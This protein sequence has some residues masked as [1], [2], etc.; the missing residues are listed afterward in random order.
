MTDIDRLLLSSSRNPHVRQQRPPHRRARR[1]RHRSRGDGAGAGSAAQDRGDDRSEIPLHRGA[2][3]RQSLSRDRQV[4][5]GKHDPAVRRGRRDPARRLRPAVG[6]LPRQHRD[7]AADRAARSFR[8][9]CRGAA[10]A[11]HS[12]RAEPDRRRRCA[13]HRSRRDPGIHRGP[14][15]LD[16]QG[17][18]HR[19]RGA[20][21]AGDHAQ[22]L[23][24]IVR[25]FLPARRTPQGARQARP[26]GLRRQGQ[27]VQ[28]VC[29]L[30]RDFRRGAPNVIPRSRRTT[31]IST[32]A[33]RCW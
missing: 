11:A 7:R 29:L 28:G 18:R 21:D 6:A 16:G 26:A 33:R 32:P 13:R 5:A 30:S 19:Q 3:R 23:G 12:G 2:G 8:S 22:D 9:L 31:C 15:R 1:R 24:A 20:R 14:V 10:G 27:R 4:D 25:I 17:R